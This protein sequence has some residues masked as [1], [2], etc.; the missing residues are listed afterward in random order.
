MN[1]ILLLSKHFYKNKV[2]LISSFLFYIISLGSIVSGIISCSQTNAE[3]LDYLLQSLSVSLFTFIYFLFV[4]NEYLYKIK[5]CDA[6]ETLRCISKG[7][8]SY[9]LIGFLI[10]II[11]TLIFTV[12]VLAVN[13]IIYRI[14]DLNNSHYLRHIIKNILLNIFCVS[15]IAVFS[16]GLLS[17]IKTRIISYIFM[18]FIIFMCSPLF[19]MIASGVYAGTNVNIYSICDFFDIFPPLLKWAPIHT[20]GYSLLPYRTELIAFWTLILLSILTILIFARKRK[21]YLLLSFFC[22][23]LSLICLIG[24]FQPSSKVTMSDDPRTGALADA[25]YYREHSEIKTTPSD[26]FTVKKYSMDLT[27]DKKLQATATLELEKNELTQ[28]NFTLYHGYIVESVLDTRKNKL[29]FTQ[30]GDYIS[31][32]TGNN[33]LTEITIC[34][35]G[36]AV[37]FFSNSQGICLPG[38]FAYYPHP[39]YLSLF[40]SEQQAFERILCPDDTQ[41]LL[42]VNTPQ[43]V[44]CNLDEID[45]NVFSGYSSGIT[46]VSGFYDSC[47]YN[48]LEIIYPSLSTNEFSYEKMM[49]AADEYTRSGIFKENHKKI[50][51]LPNTN[52]GS[53]YERFCEFSDHITLQQFT[54]LPLVYEMQKIPSYKSSLYNAYN[55]Y[56]TDSEFFNCI[57]A[58][59]ED[60]G[61]DAYILLDKALH[62]LD[63][64]YIEKQITIYLNDDSDH[65]HGYVFLKDLLR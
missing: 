9:Y 35:S 30:T 55:T 11:S 26:T 6:E 15:I 24:Y 58:D 57:V 59:R 2:L 64:S 44:Y 41:F 52:M 56:K 4:S 19:R 45:N 51:V 28:Y 43:K 60:N 62:Q 8:F 53:V 27:I 17:F 18:I 12:I 10:L 21:K 16:G 20:F 31:V 29:N 32:D 33:S 46:L 37:K 36:S 5:Q 48:N 3:P 61:T 23:G 25:Y 63:E 1:N 47:S 38:W 22:L 54:E 39:G 65:R 14:L 13:I 34:Y 49:S 7:Y 42:T 40:D 50:I